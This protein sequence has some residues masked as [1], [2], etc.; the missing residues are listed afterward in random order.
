MMHP[1]QWSV[2]TRM[3]LLGVLPT[4]SLFLTLFGWFIDQRLTDVDRALREKGEL[5]AR[6]AAAVSAMSLQLGNEDALTR[7]L[8]PM[9][10]SEVAYIAL[11]D[12][13]EKMLAVAESPQPTSYR[14]LVLFSTPITRDIEG[15]FNGQALGYI[16]VAMT[17]EPWRQTRERVFIGSAIIGC[18]SLFIAVVMAYGLGL[19]ITRPLEALTA[20]VARLQGG[21]WSA[22]GHMR[23]G[24]EIGQLQAGINSMA[25]R[26]EQ[27][28]DEQRAHVDSLGMAQQHA[29]QA[30]RAKSEFLATMSHELRTPMVG[31]LGVLELMQDTPLSEQ[32][33]N[34]LQI[35]NDCTHHLLHLVNEILD[36]SR[37]ERGLL[38]LH[39]AYFALEPT[40]N[41]CLA[42][43]RRECDLKGLALNLQIAPALRTIE[44]LADETRFRQMLINLLGNAGKFTH[45]GSIVLSVTGTPLDTEHVELQ[46]QV[47]DTGIGIP[48]E[49]QLLVFEAFRQADNRLERPYS[50]SGLG[51]A[52]V[53]SLCEAMEGKINLESAPGQGTTFTIHLH[54]R[55]RE[56]E[57]TA[58]LETLN[59]HA[60]PASGH[61]MLVED[62][63]VNQLVV[64]A[65]LEGAGYR[66]TVASSGFE[67]L[68]KFG[69]DK[70]DLVL[71]DCQM[72]GMD[73]LETTQRLRLSARG[74]KVPI[75]ALTAN[76]TEE[77]RER[78]INAGMNA[79]M[80]KPVKREKLLNLISEWIQGTPNST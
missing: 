57:Q 79:Y 52:I 35:A 70:I 71:M 56:I 61:L 4:A 34:Y 74:R 73:G 80:S 29:E 47:A 40:L 20:L 12:T 72:P 68:E 1:A 46:I 55:Y 2:K 59:N 49:K 44:I 9:L 30:N 26:I 27:Q 18:M 48:P 41:Q 5:T 63:P 39:P 3:V 45:Q 38:E 23:V 64:R 53:K 43:I 62:N 60:P 15:Q 66:V 11:F 17:P 42:T 37:I 77:D 28:R 6:H 69:G 76:A 36:F 21:E 65:M 54:T 13:N 58:A 51:L 31:A 8:K 19:G 16:T 14:E 75:V 22:R 25:E 32:Q 33:R 78:C 7:P 67:A 24:G 50:G 10:S